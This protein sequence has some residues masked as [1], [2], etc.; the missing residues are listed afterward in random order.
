MPVN[1]LLS[2]PGIAVGSVDAA[3]VLNHD[4]AE[5]TQTRISEGRPFGLDD[6]PVER[7][8]A[9][10]HA[11]MAALGLDESPCQPG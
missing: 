3:D 6:V 7:G 11:G 9:V 10:N 1:R 2:E 4:T 5:R 8:S